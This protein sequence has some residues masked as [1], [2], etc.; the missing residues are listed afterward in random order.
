MNRASAAKAVDLMPIVR[1]PSRSEIMEYETRTE[2]RPVRTRIDDAGAKKVRE[3]G[4]T[5]PLSTGKR[6]GMIFAALREE[7]RARLR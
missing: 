7:M 5:Q 6:D 2:S 3:R 1:P 4:P